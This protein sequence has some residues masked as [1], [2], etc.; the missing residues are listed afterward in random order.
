MFGWLLLTI[1]VLGLFGAFV[2]VGIRLLV[3]GAIGPDTFAHIE[4]ARQ[5]RRNRHHLPDTVERVTLAPDYDYPFLYHWL[6]SIVPERQVRIAEAMTGPISDGLQASAAA[7]FACVVFQLFGLADEELILGTIVVGVLVALS[8]ALLNMSGGPR[9]YIGSPRPIGQVLFV[10]FVNAALIWGLTDNWLWLLLSAAAIALL[11][12]ASKFGNQAAVLISIAACFLGVF[13]PL[14]SC[15]L[16]YALAAIV[17]RK[18]FFRCVSG[19]IKHSVFY[20]RHLQEPYLDRIYKAIPG[21]SER[22]ITAARYARLGHPFALDWLFADENPVHR[23][24]FQFP[25]AVVGLGLWAY[26]GVQGQALFF[27]YWPFAAV[28]MASMAVS[29]LTS[30]QRFRFLGEHYRYLEHTVSTQAILAVGIAVSVQW[31]YAEA[32]FCAAV[33]LG[34]LALVSAGNRILTQYKPLDREWMSISEGAELIDRPDTIVHAMGGLWWPV[35][36]QSKEL[37]IAHWGINCDIEAVGVENFENLY[38]NFPRPGVAYHELAAA[39]GVTHAL[40]RTRDFEAYANETGDATF[41]DGSRVP[42]YS[43]NGIVFFA[44]EPAR[45][46]QSKN[47]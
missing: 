1:I 43:G 10:L 11:A 8:P 12:V 32:A 35:W 17:W 37:T 33:F 30:T 21:Y 16:G 42:L 41:C 44:V 31:T 9:A 20:V 47:A 45:V 2:R 7:L 38:G 46:A 28:I 34:L 18:S 19:H 23:L 36:S 40:G 24:L 25:A 29:L 5:I 26:M 14:I 3:P 13:E 15:A 4:V 22:A 6:L 27:D 39:Y